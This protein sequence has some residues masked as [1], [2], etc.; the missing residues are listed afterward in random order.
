[1]W[2]DVFSMNNRPALDAWRQ[3]EQAEVLVRIFQ[4]Y[5]REGH[6][7]VVD[8][9]SGREGLGVILNGHGN[10]SRHVQG[11]LLEQIRRDEAVSADRGIPFLRVWVRNAV[12]A[13]RCRTSYPRGLYWNADRPA[14]ESRHMCT[15]VMDGD[16]MWFKGVYPP[17]RVEAAPE[18]V[19]RHGEVPRKVYVRNFN[20]QWKTTRHYGQRKLLMSEIEFL[21]IHAQ[22]GD[23]VVYA[24][25]APGSHVARLMNM[26]ASLNLQFV[27]VDPA[28]SDIPDGDRP[29]GGNCRCIARY[30]ELGASG[31]T[32][33]N[34]AMHW[35]PLKDKVLFVSDIR[36]NTSEEPDGKPTPEDVERDMQR[37]LAWVDAMRPRAGMLK[38]RLPW[39]PTAVRFLPGEIRLPVWGG[40]RTTE[41][42]LMFTAESAYPDGELVYADYDAEV[43]EQEMFHYNTGTRVTMYANV[44]DGCRC[45]DCASERLILMGFLDRFNPALPQ[46]DKEARVTALRLEITGDDPSQDP[47]LCSNQ[48]RGQDAVIGDGGGPAAR[49]GDGGVWA[50]GRGRGDAPAGRGGLQRGRGRRPWGRGA[51]PRCEFTE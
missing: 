1:M 18:R 25:G 12:S 16:R 8:G 30:F 4:I 44:P 26:F 38:F 37:Q 23:T 28:F 5:L 50:V 35:F 27:L 48:P 21:T 7:G 3:R 45:C 49:H 6:R 19:L 46:G 13:I 24:G 31:S 32:N 14:P 29:R 42:R 22:D 15:V 11:A 51:G 41:C 2:D 10:V 9:M 36:T 17:T 40:V 39:M 47:R 43:Y 20:E 33:E 34:E